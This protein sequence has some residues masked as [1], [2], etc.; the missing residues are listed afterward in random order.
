MSCQ[1]KRGTPMSTE[2]SAVGMLLGVEDAGDGLEGEDLLAGLGGQ[3]LHD[4]AHA[5]AAGLR[6]RAVG[7]EDLDVVG[8]ARRA[9]RRGSP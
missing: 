7:I 9:R 5:V 8:G 2:I 4:A 1:P 6:H 3:R